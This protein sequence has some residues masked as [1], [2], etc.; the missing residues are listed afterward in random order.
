VTLVNNRIYPHLLPPQPTLPALTFFRV[1][2]GGTGVEYSHGGSSNLVSPRYQVDAWAK[3]SV[4][5]AAVSAQVLAALSGRR[6][7]FGAEVARSSFAVDPGRDSYEP[8]T[9]L[10]RRTFEFEI[11]HAESA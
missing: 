11:Q 5:R 1:T 7:A 3:T 6:G 10:Y 9:K 8:E 4:D 2:P